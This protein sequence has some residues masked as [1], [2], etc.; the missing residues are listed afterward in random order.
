MMKD[1]QLIWR[2]EAKRCGW[3]SNLY[4]RVGEE[5]PWSSWVKSNAYSE[6]CLVWIKVVLK[7]GF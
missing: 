5:G 7:G 6:G 3:N 2:L 4:T 1:N